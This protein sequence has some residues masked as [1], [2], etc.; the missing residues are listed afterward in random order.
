MR[1]IKKWHAE[2]RITNSTNFYRFCFGAFVSPY[3]DYFPF[4]SDNLA[5]TGTIAALFIIEVIVAAVSVGI[6]VVVLWLWCRRWGAADDTNEPCEQ[7]DT[8]FVEYKYA[9]CGLIM[10]PPRKLICIYTAY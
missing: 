8:K 6:I 2:V 9:I 5:C 10:Q 7:V 3:I 4:I 1:I